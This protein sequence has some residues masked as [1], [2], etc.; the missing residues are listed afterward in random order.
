MQRVNAWLDE[1]VDVEVGVPVCVWRV[2]RALVEAGLCVEVRGVLER[3]VA[4]KKGVGSVAALQNV[5]AVLT[6]L[7]DADEALGYLDKCDEVEECVEDEV[8]AMVQVV[9]GDALVRLGRAP[10]AVPLYSDVVERM[11]EKAKDGDEAA[12]RVAA[13]PLSLR[14]HCLRWGPFARPQKRGAPC[15]RWACRCRPATTPV[16]TITSTPLHTSSPPAWRGG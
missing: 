3:V 5:A 15:S 8:R 6:L 16:T 10:E 14:A 12:A 4:K 11:V 1:C 2:V 7:G 9:R 13:R